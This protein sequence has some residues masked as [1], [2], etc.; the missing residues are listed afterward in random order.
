[1]IDRLAG[2][3]D[4][5]RIPFV[6]PMAHSSSGDFSFSGIKTQAARWVAEH[7]VPSD[8]KLLADVCASFQRAV[9]DVLASKLLAAAAREGVTDV[10]LGGGVAA[11]SELRARVSTLAAAR[12]MRA[13]VPPL[14]SCTDNAA[15]IAYAGLLRLARGERD[16]WDL[17]A[18]STTAL[19]RATRK[20]RGA[21]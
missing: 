2:Q 13:F 11:N 3:G 4:P 10:V 12:G 15:M 7:G 16:S 6:A 14:A 19:P 18:T 21:R 1:V 9:V 20:G 17:V 5:T 8:P